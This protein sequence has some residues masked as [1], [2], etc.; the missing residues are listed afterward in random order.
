MT[1][2]MQKKIDLPTALSWIIGSVFLIT[3]SIYSFL[4]TLPQTGFSQSSVEFIIRKIIQTGPQR[5]ALT[6]DHLAEI[7]GLSQDV[8]TNIFRF[9]PDEA[10]QKLLAISLLKEAKV[11]LIHPD[12][13]YV[14]YTMRE[15]I[16]MVYDYENIAIDEEGFLFPFSPF[17][18]PKALPEFYFG[19]DSS[20]SWDKPIKSASF[21]LARRLLKL[22]QPITSEQHLCLKR[23]DVSNA[24]HKSLG[25]QEVVIEITHEAQLF[26]LAPQQRFV[27]YLRLSPQNYGQQLG[28]YFALHRELVIGL[29]LQ[30]GIQTRVI[31]L[32]I[33]GFALVNE[34]A[35]SN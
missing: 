34:P 29:S 15:P 35:K 9:D 4:K 26:T 28:N 24:F 30:E 19:L 3:G 14:D 23:I 8:P 2:W 20:F 25:R 11:E 27:H 1:T 5:D 13:V 22:L 17:Y 12:T 10:T 18:S 16:A 7:M 6:T 33:E 32:R 21:D 31:D